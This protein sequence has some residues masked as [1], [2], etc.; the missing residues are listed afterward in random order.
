M[1]VV[2]SIGVAVTNQLV[3]VTNQLPNYKANI[4]KKVESVRGS[5]R[6]A[7]V[8]ASE[9]VNELS[10]EVVEAPSATPRLPISA[11][12]LARLNL[13]A[14]NPSTCKWCRPLTVRGS[15]CT[16]GWALSVSQEL[17]WSSQ[18]SCFCEE[19]I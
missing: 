13:R 10:R 12:R 7:L 14:I 9:T 17:C 5:N 3:D 4:Q 19:R 16:V 2:G 1:A 18:F 11:N 8:R 6:A 15:F